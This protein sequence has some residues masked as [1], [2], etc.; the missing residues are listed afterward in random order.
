MSRSRHNPNAAPVSLFP[1]LAVL[2]CTMGALVML[3]VAMTHVSRENALVAAEATAVVQPAPV[4]AEARPDPGAE[5]RREQLDKAKAYLTQAAS[6][7]EKIESKLRQDQLRLSQ[8]EDHIRRLTDHL[9]SL[10]SAVAELRE[11]DAKH[12]DDRAQAER[13][14]KQLEELIAETKAEIEE[15]EQEGNEQFKSYAI[16]PYKGANGTRRQPIY[17]ECRG[18]QVLLQPEGVALT[19]AD[20]KKP[21]G[22]GNPLAAALRA[23]R[24]YY[25]RNNPD[26]GYDPDAE[27]YP[28]IIVRPDG[29]LAYYGVREAIR[30]WDSD[31]GYEMVAADWVLKFPAPN[32]VLFDL[33]ARAIDR[34]RLRRNLLARAAPRAYGGTG[35]Q[36]PSATQRTGTG[37]RQP[38]DGGVI[39]P[40]N[41]AAQ[42]SGGLTSFAGGQEFAGGQDQAAGGGA[43][44]T[45]VPRGGAPELGP[46]SPA[47]AFAGES[48]PGNPGD[49]ASERF[50]LEADG[51][52]GAAPSQATTEGQRSS[53]TPGS[54]ASAAAQ[55]ASSSGGSGQPS[56][57]GSSAGSSSRSLAITPQANSRGADWAVDKNSPRDIPIQR[58]VQVMVRGDRLVLL[59]GR[60]QSALRGG[61]EDAGKT[62]YLDGATQNG[63]DNFVTEVRNQVQSWGMAGQGLYWRPVL[64]LNVAPDG[65]GRADDLVRLLERSGIDVRYERTATLPN[66][67]PTQSRSSR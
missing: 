9:R 53:D 33:Q 21:L 64:M 35:G 67:A 13:N 11:V 50:S 7:S 45:D 52:R 10:R 44:R 5:K 46:G 43:P 30:S 2:L 38:Y 29:V 34:A 32:P 8:T 12:Y 20:F 40:S 18:E 59:P 23:T 65:A 28:L 60:D 27:P 57:P 14:L 58:S 62:V 47:T 49:G 31:F 3:L 22:I 16:V 39:G 42:R 63:L 17:I 61:G 26:A 51:G 37:P 54:P 48:T 15:L 1:F 24:E 66:A 6:D 36:I 56:A 19:P 4:V 55:A 25:A 41:G